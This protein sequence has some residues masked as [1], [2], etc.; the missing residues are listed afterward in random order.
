[1][2]KSSTRIGWVADNSCMDISWYEIQVPPDPAGAPW[3]NDSRWTGMLCDILGTCNEKQRRQVTALL[4]LCLEK[5]GQTKLAEITGISNQTIGRGRKEL[6]GEA[7]SPDPKRIRKAGAGRKKKEDI[8]GGIEV[9]LLEIVEAHKAGNPE[10][11]D[12]WAGRSLAKLQAALQSRGYGASKNTIRRLLKKTRFHSSAT[13][14]V[15]PV[16]PILTATPNSNK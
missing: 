6:L 12:V 7:K 9:A 3:L 1:M 5:G 2:R 13:V 16:H 14:K 11:P 15:S 4:S 8:D 10:K